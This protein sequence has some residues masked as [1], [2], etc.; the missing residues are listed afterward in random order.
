MVR[1]MG[2]D[3]GLAIAGFAILEG[4]SQHM[5]ALHYGSIET[6]SN[7][8]LPCRLRQLYDAV[9]ELIREFCPQELAVEDLFFNRNVTTAFTVGQARGVFLLAAEQQGLIYY[10]YTPAQVK[11]A[12]T[13]YGR[14]DKPQIQQ[15]VKVLLGLPAVPKPDDTADALAIAICHLQ[16]SGMRQILM[17]RGK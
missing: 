16:S 7:L 5:R 10:Q 15:M 1:V 14:A 6:K 17:E 9:T 3:P 2:I 13:G 4:D 12:V 8:T 11:Q